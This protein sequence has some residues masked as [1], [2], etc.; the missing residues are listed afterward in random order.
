MPLP[1]PLVGTV[2]AAA[3]F[4]EVVLAAVMFAI[5][6]FRSGGLSAAPAAADL[7]RRRR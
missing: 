2:E 5:P 4:G 1:L 3:G 6:F 7:L